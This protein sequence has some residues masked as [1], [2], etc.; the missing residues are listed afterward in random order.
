[1][2]GLD[3]LGRRECRAARPEAETRRGASGF[4]YPISRPWRAEVEAKVLMAVFAEAFRPML[5][6]MRLERAALLVE[7]CPAEEPA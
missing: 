1:L 5:H 7:E 3:R 2:H 4:A 6:L